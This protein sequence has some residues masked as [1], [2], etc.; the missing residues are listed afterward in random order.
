MTEPF[1][2]APLPESVPLSSLTLGDPSASAEAP[3]ARRLLRSLPPA[4]RP[5]ERLLDRGAHALEPDELLALVLGTGRGTQED[6]LEL[7]R[8]VLVELDGVEG[9]AAATVERL[10]AVHGIG[11]VKASRI[12]AAFELA[13]R[14]GP[15]E[16]EAVPV[17]PLVLHLERLRGQVPTGQAT[18]LGYQPDS[19]APPLPLGTGPLG[20]TTRAG[21]LLAQLLVAAQAG[22]WWIV[23]VRPGGA[24]R[25]AEEGAAGRLFHAAAALDFPLEQ[26]LVV[27]SREAWPLRM[28]A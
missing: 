21:A 19:G 23:A 20:A 11:P 24:P 16:P 13:L 1:L 12:R 18:L 17:D 27:G 14:A 9:L 10:L 15:V 8:R 28:A 6:V 7:A 4:D 2:P 25:K 3:A 5:R 26:V 22:R